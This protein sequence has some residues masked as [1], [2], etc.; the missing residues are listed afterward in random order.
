[1]IINTGIRE[2]V[3]NMDYP[4][5]ETAMKLLRSYYFLEREEPAYLKSD[6]AESANAA[7]LPSYESIDVLRQAKNKKALD[8]KEYTHLKKDVFEKGKAATDVRRSLTAMIRQREEA[9]PKEAW[10]KKRHSTVKRFLSVLKSLKQEIEIAKLV[11]APLIKE[12]AALIKKLESE[13]S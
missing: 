5:G 4:L 2:V 12:T 9:D 3:F 1:M 11:P 8:D 10:E 6:Y 7:S 13:I